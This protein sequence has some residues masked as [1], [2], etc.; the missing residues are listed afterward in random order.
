MASTGVR[1]AGFYVA[2][3]EY[4]KAVQS[5]KELVDSTIRDSETRVRDLQDRYQTQFQEHRERIESSANRQITAKRVE[6]DGALMDFCLEFT[7]FLEE[8]RDQLTQEQR[9]VLFALPD[10]GL[11]GKFFPTEVDLRRHA[12]KVWFRRA[13]T[14]VEQELSKY[15]K[16][17]PRTIDAL[18]SGVTSFLREFSFEL[19]SLEGKLGDLAAALETQKREAEEIRRGAMSEIEVQREKLIRQFRLQVTSLHESIVQKIQDRNLWVSRARDNLRKEAA[20]VGINI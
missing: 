1:K 8:L 3:D 2:R 18:F 15:L 11:F 7:E 6:Y 9:E 16:L 20:A 19:Q 17:E 4:N 5:A 10:S 13:R 12:I 14:T